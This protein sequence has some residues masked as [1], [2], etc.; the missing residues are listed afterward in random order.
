MGLLSKVIVPSSF[1]NINLLSPVAVVINCK[2]NAR[3]IN[4]IHIGICF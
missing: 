2:E 1:L 3:I 4:G